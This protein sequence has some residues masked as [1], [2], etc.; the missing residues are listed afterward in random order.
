MDEMIVQGKTSC[1]TLIAECEKEVAGNIP[2]F[3]AFNVSY[4][5]NLTYCMST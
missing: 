5:L 4:A 1:E 2:D 3:I